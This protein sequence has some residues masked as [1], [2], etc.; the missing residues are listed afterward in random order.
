MAVGATIAITRWVALLTSALWLA[1]CAD[2]PI[3][4]SAGAPLS[5]S[6]VPITLS[7][8]DQEELAGTHEVRLIGDGTEIE[9]T[10]SLTK[11][12]VDDVRTL[13]DSHPGIKVIQLT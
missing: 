1:G 10:G 12:A 13:L 5:A 7:V 9:F 8:A 11:A 6:A 4:T 2:Q 3:A